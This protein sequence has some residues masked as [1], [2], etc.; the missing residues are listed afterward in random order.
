MAGRRANVG[1]PRR[2]EEADC[3]GE[4]VL[5]IE[6]LFGFIGRQ[7]ELWRHRQHSH[8]ITYEGRVYEIRFVRKMAVRAHDE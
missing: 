5:E 8:L 6:I 4:L 3:F 7:S 1:Q 2:R